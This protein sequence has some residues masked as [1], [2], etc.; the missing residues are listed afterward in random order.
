MKPDIE[1]N[2]GETS[3]LVI[4]CLDTR[5]FI[6][7]ELAVTRDSKTVISKIFHFPKE[8]VASFAEHEKSF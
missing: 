1:L 7:E 5:D 3:F 8:F 6:L 4:F 2:S